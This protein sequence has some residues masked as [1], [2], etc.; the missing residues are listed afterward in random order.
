MAVDGSESQTELSNLTPGVT[1][2]ITVIAIKGQRE[3]E[4][5]SDTVTTGKVHALCIHMIKTRFIGV[6]SGRVT[7]I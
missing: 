7:F 1:Y 4:P 6:K 3:S 5:G 2:Q